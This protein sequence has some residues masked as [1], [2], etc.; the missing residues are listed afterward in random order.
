MTEEN[1][2]LIELL[3]NIREE[4]REIKM[5]LN[6]LR[7]ELHRVTIDTINKADKEELA[8][9]LDRDEFKKYK[10]NIQNTITI[11]IIFLVLVAIET[12]T[13]GGVFKMLL[14]KF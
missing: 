7:E 6:S 11:I 4:I 13:F 2:M 3:N 1:K 14:D 10:K 9:K 12:N 5:D 8:K